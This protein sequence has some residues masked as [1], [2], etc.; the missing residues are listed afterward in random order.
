MKSTVK[1]LVSAAALTAALTMVGGYA[2]L[3]E[4][5][6]DHAP[7]HG[8]DCGFGD[9]HSTK[10]KNGHVGG[11]GHVPGHHKGATYCP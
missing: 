2:A 11:D 7:A 9:N 8:K 5:P 1:R 3:A 4:A 10:A 6:P